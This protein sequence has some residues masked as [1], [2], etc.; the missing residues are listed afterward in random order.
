MADLP[1]L[2]AGLSVAPLTPA[3]V[4]D[5]AALLVAAE[6]VDDTGEHWSAEDLEEWWVNDLVDLGRDGLALRDADGA[7]VAWATVARACPRSARPSGSTSRRGCTPPGADR[8]HRPRRCSRG[9]WRAGARST[10]NGTG[11]SPAVLA[12]PVPSP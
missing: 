11:G 4:A 2:P 9:S 1:A 7:L 8:G 10:P 5:A 3:D 6:A 12:V